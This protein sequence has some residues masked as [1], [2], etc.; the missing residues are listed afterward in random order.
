MLIDVLD[1]LVIFKVPDLNVTFR[2]CYHNVF[3]WDRVD[4]GNSV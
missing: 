1:T 4:L 3:V 2:D